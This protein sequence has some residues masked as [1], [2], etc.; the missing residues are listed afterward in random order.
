M[1]GSLALATIGVLISTRQC[2]VAPES[3]EVT[4]VV[5]EGQVGVGSGARPGLVHGCGLALSVQYWI[6]CGTPP[7]PAPAGNTGKMWMRR[8]LLALPSGSK[9]RTIASSRSKVGSLLTSKER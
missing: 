4:G 1:P 3:S 5:S 6:A 9:A 8:W 2:L 7:A